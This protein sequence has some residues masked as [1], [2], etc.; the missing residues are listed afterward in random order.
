MSA[1]GGMVTAELT[2]FSELSLP[3]PVAPLRGAT[4]PPHVVGREWDLSDRP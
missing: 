2:A 3:T 1:M 4:G